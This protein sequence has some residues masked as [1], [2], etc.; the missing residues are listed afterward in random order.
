MAADDGEE[1]TPDMAQQGIDPRFLHDEPEDDERKDDD[2]E[3]V[4]ALF[5]DHYQREK[6]GCED[7]QDVE[8]GALP[9][10]GFLVAGVKLMDQNTEG[11]I[12]KTTDEIQVEAILDP[13]ALDGSII[14]EDERV[15][16]NDEQGEH[17]RARQL[18]VIIQQ[19]VDEEPGDDQDAEKPRDI[20]DRK[21][22]G[23]DEA[24][25]KRQQER[26]RPD[27]TYECIETGEIEPGM[28]DDAGKEETD[29]EGGIEFR[30]SLACILEC[31]R[32]L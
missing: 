31:R 14:A 4:V 7:E 10:D 8:P 26:E 16:E 5:R 30:D 29:K 3:H 32:P 6:H 22:N 1:T 9:V 28:E 23:R 20:Q 24:V 21:G 15:S 12:A 27:R 18:L 17:D 19:C 11:H 13:S 2:R 25:C